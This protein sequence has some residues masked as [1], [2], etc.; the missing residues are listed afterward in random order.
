MSG[1]AH[2]KGDIPEFLRRGPIKPT[3]PTKVFSQ[4][5]APEPVG[6]KTPAETVDIAKL[7]DDGCPNLRE[8]E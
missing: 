7:A 8:D 4:V 3:D 5:P 6:L 2:T 1:E